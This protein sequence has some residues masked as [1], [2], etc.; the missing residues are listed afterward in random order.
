VSSAELVFGATLSP[1]EL[2]ASPEP[3]AQ[4]FLQQLRQQPL[5][6]PPTRPLSY[7]EAASAPSAQLMA[8]KFVFVRRGAANTPLAPLYDGPFLVVKRGQ[9]TFELEVGGR[10]EVVSVDRLKPYLGVEVDPAQPPRR[11]RPPGSSS[12]SPG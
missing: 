1:G 3:P 5:P 4:E 12:A 2:L 6:P 11:G 8:A 7:S 9:K 10:R